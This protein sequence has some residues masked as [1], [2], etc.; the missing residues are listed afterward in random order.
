M[1]GCSWTASPATLR[2]IRITGVVRE[3]G[4]LVCKPRG[5]GRLCEGVNTT[6]VRDVLPTISVPTLILHKRN[7]AGIPLEEGKYIAD[8][9]PGAKFVELPGSGPWPWD[10]HVVEEIQE[11]LTGIRDVAESDRVPRP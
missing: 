10:E 4:A 1:S 11:F 5:G 9:V 2:T 7:D 8:R 3:T 6:Y